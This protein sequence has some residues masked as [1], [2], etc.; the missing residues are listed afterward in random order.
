MGKKSKRRGGGKNNPGRIGA[1][2]VHVSTAASSQ[3]AD[4]WS[5]RSIVDVEHV[6]TMANN[7]NDDES[8]D[9]YNDVRSLRGITCTNLD[10]SKCAICQGEIVLDF[11]LP[12]PRFMWIACCGKHVCGS[13]FDDNA[14]TH[15]DILGYYRCT[16]CNAVRRDKEK[17][18]RNNA[19]LGK[20]WAQYQLGF[21]LQKESA[22][23]AI[24]WFEKAAARGHPGACFELAIYLLGKEVPRNLAKAEFYAER[25]R[26][27]HSKFVPKTNDLLFSIARCHFDFKA[28][29]DA[30]A[31]RILSRLIAD[32]RASSIMSR[33]GNLLYDCMKWYDLAALAYERCAIDGSMSAPLFV[34]CSYIHMQKY[35]LGKIWLLYTYKTR[36]AFAIDPSEWSKHQDRR[37]EC[38]KILREIRNSCGGCGATLQGETRKY[39]AGCQA[40]C[41]CSRDCQKRHWNRSQDGHK[42][43]CKEAGKCVV[44]LQALLDK[45]SESK[46][47]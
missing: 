37:D 19:N 16:L 39:C 34:A 44:K 33:V 43:E 2:Q 13:C 12:G 1:G 15:Q 18:L 6:G 26:A 42:E 27:I 14:E 3:S 5:P 40:H 29:D 7:A 11:E 30:A 20:P 10:P 24:N 32:D 35:S 22:A 21:D 47:E 8:W 38:R 46:S 9:R 36:S 31:E 45:A 4:N 17:V 28:Y 41:Y 23:Q 25:L